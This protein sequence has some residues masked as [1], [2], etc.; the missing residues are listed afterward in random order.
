MTAKPTSGVIGSDRRIKLIANARQR[1][2]K[3]RSL[4]T[5]MVHGD[6][7]ELMILNINS[8]PRKAVGSCFS[9]PIYADGS[10]VPWWLEFG[11][12]KVDHTLWVELFDN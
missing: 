5:G 9:R 1:Q 3:W 8:A 10:N 2:L 12:L 11:L 4:N 7:S 6:P